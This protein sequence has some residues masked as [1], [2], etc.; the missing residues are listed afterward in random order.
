MEG[1]GLTTTFADEADVHPEAL[2]TVKLYVPAGSA[3][4]LAVA[5]VPVVVTIP[6][7]RVSVQVPLAGIPVRLIVPV[8]TAHVGWTI[9]PAA[10]GVGI[11]GCGLTTTA[12]DGDDVQ[13]L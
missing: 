11:A 1:C 13:P 9:S 8:E 5:P 6:G 3:G 12:A 10:G 4:M 7:Y 2:V